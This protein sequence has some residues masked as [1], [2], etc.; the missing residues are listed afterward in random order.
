MKGEAMGMG[1]HGDNAATYA[2]RAVYATGEEAQKDA[3]GYGLAAI[4]LAL[5]ELANNVSDL[6]GEVVA[7]R[8]ERRQ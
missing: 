8:K 3:I 1:L 2:E 6:C 5:L 4:A 7:S